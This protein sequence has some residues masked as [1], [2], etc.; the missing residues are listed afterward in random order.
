MLPYGND[1]LAKLHEEYHLYFELGTLFTMIAGLL[2][3]LAIY[4]AYAGP[5]MGAPD[6]KGNKPPPD[7]S[8]SSKE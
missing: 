7:S 3:I 8:R 6:P 4:D 2:N 1:D 5:V